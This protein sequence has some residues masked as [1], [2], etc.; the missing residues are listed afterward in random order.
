MRKRGR[1]EG[2]DYIGSRPHPAP[3]SIMRPLIAVIGS[4]EPGRVYDPPAEDAVQVDEA[5]A[6]MGRELAAK[7]CRIVVFSSRPQ[8]VERAVVRGFVESGQA[9][10]GS[11]EVRARF[12]ADTAFEEMNRHPEAFAVRPEPAGDWEV[13][14]Y[15]SLLTVDGVL[16][17]GGGRATFAAGLIALSRRVAIAPVAVFGGAA[18]RIWRRLEGSGT[19]AAEDDIA[20]L[21]QPW[22]A[23]SAAGVVAVLLAQHQRRVA[24]EALSRRGEASAR[25]RTVAALV[26][27]LVLLLLAL[28]TIPLA[29]ALP[30]GMWTGLTVLV[31]AALV[32]SIWGAVIRN[33]YDGGAEWLR[34]A[35]LGSAAGSIAFLLFVAAQMATNPNLLT[36]DGARRLIFFVLAIGF[37]GGFTSEVVY[38][39]LR[40]Q[41]VT[42]TPV[43]PP[44]GV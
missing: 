25:R 21:A 17:V 4:M 14:F 8:Y 33:A 15:R 9:R 44:P 24:A 2:G 19:Y 38:R 42:Q 28:A 22:A 13:A 5:A 1:G 31:T 18:L 43:L 6:A 23:D 37:I 20:A 41:D 40:D 39:K 11:V 32:A 10:P 35:A 12:G 7:N 34:A 36:G 26:A 3:G 30:I 16:L 29:F 27:A